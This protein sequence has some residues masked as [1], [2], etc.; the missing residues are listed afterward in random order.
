VL[1]F[2]SQT[3]MQL[4]MIQESYSRTPC[5]RESRRSRRNPRL[6][7]LTGCGEGLAAGLADEVGRV[8]VRGPD[9]RQASALAVRWIAAVWSGR[10]PWVARH[11]FS[12]VDDW[13]SGGN[14][15]IF[16]DYLIN[17]GYRRLADEAGD[18]G[19]DFS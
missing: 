5:G 2:R 11:C 15:Q 4:K 18:S 12:L 17:M 8:H 9:F 7:L 10:F 6:P 3:L 1:L 13:F 14:F 19:P 16:C